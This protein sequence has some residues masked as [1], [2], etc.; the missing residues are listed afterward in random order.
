MC[1]CAR[2]CVCASARVCASACARVCVRA[3]WSVR[4]ARLIGARAR[5]LNV[6]IH[7][8]ATSRDDR[9]GTRT[10][11]ELYT[12]WDPKE[13]YH[14]VAMEYTEFMRIFAANG[15]KYEWVWNYPVDDITVVDRIPKRGRRDDDDDHYGPPAAAS[16]PK[17]AAS[18]E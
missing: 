1:V 8:W 2:V 10:A 12:Q 4:G 18:A 5:S 6:R 11:I 16:T 17:R 15:H 7:A 13:E 9:A 14:G 3:C